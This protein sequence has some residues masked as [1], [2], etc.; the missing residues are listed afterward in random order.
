MFWVFFCRVATVLLLTSCVV[1]VR[2][3]TATRSPGLLA[4][5][6]IRLAGND[7]ARDDPSKNDREPRTTTRTANGL[8]NRSD[9]ISN[10]RKS[11][12]S[13]HRLSLQADRQRWG[14]TPATLASSNVCI[15]TVRALRRL[16]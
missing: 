16:P 8:P 15:S 2:A 13:I 9:G 11:K 14:A 4:T 10:H 12:P 3:S 5:R 1:A 7:R 6:C